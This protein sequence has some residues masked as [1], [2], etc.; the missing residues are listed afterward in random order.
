MKTLGIKMDESCIKLLNTEECCEDKENSLKFF[1]NHRPIFDIRNYIGE[2]GDRVL[3]SFGNETM[4]ELEAQLLSLDA[5]TLK[6]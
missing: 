5:Q 1:I 6:P 4:E 3:I 2:D